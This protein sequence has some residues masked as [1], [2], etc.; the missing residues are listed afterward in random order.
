[1]RYLRM[2]TN[3]VAG[4]VL[5]AMYIAVLVF[6]LN[7][8]LPA[9][10][11]TAG[12]WVG[13]ILAFY[14]PY[15]TAALYFLILGRDLFASVPLRPAWLSVRLLA[16]LGTVATA[17]A[18]VLT[19]ANLAAFSAVLSDE[20]AERMRAGAVA[21][22]GIAVLLAAIVMLRYSFGRRG[23][24]PVGG[25]LVASVLLAV[26]VP[27]WLRGPGEV[28]VRLPR[29]AADERPASLRW[30]LAPITF[31]PRVRLFAFDGASLGFIRQRVAAGQ[32]PN[33][34]RLLDRGATIDLAT[35]K[36]TQAEPI[37]AAAATGKSAEKN[38][39]RSNARYRITATDQDA[40]DI[41][42]DYC[43]AS[44]LPDQGFVRRSDLTSVSLVA[45]PMWDILADY[46]VAA[47]VAGWPLTYPARADRGYVLSDR[48][49]EAASEPLRLTDADAGDPTTSVDVA[50]EIFDRWQAM[51]NDRI[52][53][54]L[55]ADAPEPS[56]LSQVRW[57]RA[58]HDAASALEP[59]FA[60][61]LIAVR[62]EGLAAFGHAFLRDAQPEL[63][64]DPRRANP[65]RSVLDQYYEFLDGEVGRAMRLLAP[66]D[67][68]L[69]VSGFG[70][71]PTALG[72]RL[73]ARLL[74][75]PDLSGTHESA[76]DGFL[77]AY[78]SSV[79]SGQ[80]ARGTIHDL[81]PTVLYYMG[82]DVGKDMD[83]FARTDLFVPAYVI[84]HPVKYVATH[85]R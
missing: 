23:S 55:P 29:Q 18:A 37:W 26:A 65:Q 40:V 4:G 83:G 34:G 54:A 21:T 24:R 70:M 43:F 80:F 50:R 25:L 39:V 46:G 10:S 17:A 68:L 75:T 6:Q 62:Y 63:F 67:L 59:Q 33:L 19:W 31:A 61:R 71:E 41:L 84:E 52:L 16:W 69:V 27:T 64:G 60:P 11:V 82:V 73:L 14:T 44:A 20:A 38:G 15:L 30:L 78:G 77:M 51:P 42:P 76:P 22:T 57:D 85:E 36:P 74:S 1:M 12:R 81:A 32:L 3:A 66:G 58:Y 9:V 56:G 7:P 13:A 2:L 72:K 5:M 53:P 47:G 49:D 35:L 45:R 48:F 28:A 8:Q 79:A